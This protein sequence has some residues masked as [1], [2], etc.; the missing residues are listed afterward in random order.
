MQGPENPPKVVAAAMPQTRVPTAG[1]ISGATRDENIAVSRVVRI[2]T[3]AWS[4]FRRRQP[5]N[6]RRTWKSSAMAP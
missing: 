3:A 6:L 2:Q 4:S 5:S 1:G